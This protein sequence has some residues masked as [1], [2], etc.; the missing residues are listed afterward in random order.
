MNPVNATK[1]ISLS[2]ILMLS[3]HLRQCF[4]SSLFPSGFHIDT[5]RMEQL[6]NTM[7]YVRRHERKWP[8]EHVN[9]GRIVS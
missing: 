9:L 5:V 3:F 6:R 8:L 4:P 2:S 1:P 7:S